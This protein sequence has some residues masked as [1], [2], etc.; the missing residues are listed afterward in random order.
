MIEIVIPAITIPPL[1]GLL[2]LVFA[3]WLSG[4]MLVYIGF[5]HGMDPL[6]IMAFP[7]FLIGIALLLS[8]IFKPDYGVQMIN[9]SWGKP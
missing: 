5:K 7:F 9:I 2:I 4:C 6:G 8:A 1:A 3:F